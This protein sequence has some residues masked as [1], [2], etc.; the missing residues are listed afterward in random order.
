MSGVDCIVIGY[1]ETPFDEYEAMVARYGA[2]SA[3][4][5]DLRLNFVEVGGRKLDYCHLINHAADDPDPGIRSGDIPNLAAAYLTN[6]LRRRHR[7]TWINLY[8]SEKERLAE[9]LRDDPV[10]VAITTTFYVVN[11]PVIELVRF[12]RAHAPDVAI[13]V[14]GPLVMNHA[15]RLPPDLL[16]AALDEIGADIFVLDG[17]GE[18]TLDAVVSVLKDGTD[19]ADV[20]N[21]LYRAGNRW[22]RT[23]TVTENNSMD[24]NVIAWDRLSDQP[25]GATVQLRTA[26]S[27]TFTCAFCAYP[28]RAGSFVATDLDAVERELDSIRALG[29]VRTIVFIDDTFNVPIRR[30]KQ[31]CRR[32]IER[33]YGFEWYSYFRCSNADE[34]SVA[35]AAASGCRGVFLGVES[36]SDT[37]LRAMNKHAAADRY[38][39]GIDVLKRHGILTFG[40]FIAG[41]PGETEATFTETLRFIERTGLDYFRVQPWYCEPGTP[42]WGRR[43]EMDIRGEGFRWSHATMSSTDAAGLAEEAFLSVRSSQWLPQWS[44]DFWVIPYL[45]GRGLS[46]A[47]FGGVMRCAN[48]LLALEFGPIAEKTSRQPALLAELG[49]A[50]APAYAG[51]AGRR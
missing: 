27:C 22:E 10:C 48:A 45:V 40:S 8:Q 17:Q 9:L 25:L 12:V 21:L 6:F 23:R 13:V 4:Y 14:G 34:E 31:L 35:L 44:F 38:E 20:P 19:L 49:R 41:F 1:N 16:P 36:G 32:L 46:H 5:R 30:F 43:A 29:T 37:V 42:I 50:A 11:F 18:S 7:A 33:D 26:R 24:D 3:A 51:A 39:W 28:A 15:R 2:D 47:Q